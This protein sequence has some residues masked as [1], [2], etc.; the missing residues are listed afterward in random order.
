VVL[1]TVASGSAFADQII[2]PA[3]VL[4]RDRPAEFVYRMDEPATGSGTLA[5]E[6]TDSYGRII[7]RRAIHFAAA[8]VSS[9]TFP[10][11]LRR[12]VAMRNEV[13]AH[14]VLRS[15]GEAGA[16]NTR[17]SD[18]RLSFI[19]APPDDPW[20]HYQIIMWQR[21][22]AREYAAL[23]ALGVTAG[24]VYAADKDAPEE[25]IN[26]QI[27]PLLKAD[28]RWYVENIATDFYAAY[29][30]WSPS[31]PVNWRFLEV[32]ERHREN[33]SDLTA[34]VRSPSLSDPQ[35]LK[36]IGDRITKTVALHRLYKPL[37]YSLGDETGI[38]DL[39]AFWD[40]DMS[41][42]SLDGMRAWLKS[43][44]GSLAA[45][46]REWGSHFAR[47]AQIMPMTTSEAMRRTDDNFSGWA[48]FKEW[49]DIAFARALKTGRH[50]AHAVDPAAYVA[51]EGAQIPGWGGYDY[52]QLA[53][54]VDVIELGDFGQNMEI[55]RSLNPRMVMLTTSADPA[56]H[57]A[58]RLWHELFRGSRGLILW[59]PKGDFVG[60]DGTPKARGRSAARYFHEVE[61]G[62]GD[63]LVNSRR[64]VEP[65]A[66][67][68]SP[69]SLRI[70]W[71]LDNRPKG[72]AW[73]KRDAEAEYEDNAI[74][75]SMRAY[76]AALEHMGFQ[77][78]MLSP[79]L[80]ERGDLARK[81]YRVLILP[82]AIA[83]SSAAADK[84]RDFVRQGGVVIA[85]GE[86]GAFDRHGRK[87]A[88]SPLSDLFAGPPP[89]QG[90]E[91]SRAIYL[92]A[93]AEPSEEFSRRLSRILEEVKIQPPFP[94]GSSD[95]AVRDVETHIFD[96]G[97]VSIIALE[98]DPDGSTTHNSAATDEGGEAISIALPHRSFVYD[99][100]RRRTLG[101]TDRI[102]LKLSSAEPAIYA[103]SKAELPGLIISVTNRIEAGETASMTLAF[104][105]HS[106]AMHDVL[107]IEI[108]DPTGRVVPYY[109]RNLVLGSGPATVTVPIAYSDP[110][111]R[112]TMRAT[113]VLSGRTVTR[114]FT[115]LDR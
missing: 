2:P 76:S 102:E 27:G 71:L 48:E 40:F 89:V 92:G 114:R 63:L 64:R 66:M 30:R 75:S 24:M 58:H 52:T 55:I 19:A 61:S 18:A 4:D 44:Y 91:Q 29:H 47:W 111:G 16:R 97:D 7:E 31:H 11:D 10:L 28:M 110:P 78:A 65:V 17:E 87:R 45:L 23:K 73:S 77:Y 68:Y 101:E 53:K 43:R 32:K 82:H 9:L 113:Y 109:S 26:T 107:H 95:G 51:I 60:E 22:S 20:S 86:P 81:G 14:L 93:P 34:F 69:Q 106:P 50:A 41:R 94:L 85:D 103:V 36:R 1:I 84:I 42:Y 108:I 90:G 33:P 99:V 59:D 38:A 67:L 49:M 57:G 83:L 115:V 74:R 96:N 13:R 70:Q 79:E 25:A 56:A 98:R 62:L 12:A 39:S 105:R 5:I 112:W 35:W 37:Y 21:R 54:A 46:N 88:R 104:R 8:H 100:R 72:E 3:P 15:G 6:W 80:I